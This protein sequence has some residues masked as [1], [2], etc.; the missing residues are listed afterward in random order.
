M[1]QLRAAGIVA[2]LFGAIASAAAQAQGLGPFEDPPI[3]ET[4]DLMPADSM[5][6]PNFSMEELTPS[7]G[8]NHLFT[9][10]TPFGLNTVE[11]RRFFE[12]RRHELLAIDHME[13][14]SRTGE[15]GD[16]MAKAAAGPFNTAADLITSPV[17]T[18]GNIISGTGKWIGGIWDSVTNWGDD[19]DGVLAAATGFAANKRATALAYQIDP[20]SRYE[21]LQAELKE[22]AWASF[23]GGFSVQVGF[24]LVPDTPGLILQI[25][26]FA[27]SMSKLVADNT[28][29]ELRT[30]NRGKLQALG[31]NEDVIDIFLASSVFS[32]TQQ[33]Y[34]VGA[35]EQMAGVENL[36]AFVK[37]AALDNTEADAFHRRLMA[38]MMAGYHQQIEPV[39]TVV[40]FNNVPFM[41]RADGVVVGTF[42]VDYV[43]WTQEAAVS[44]SNAAGEMGSAPVEIWISGFLSPLAKEK[45][46][47]Y[48]WTVNQD[49]D[50][51]L[52][53]P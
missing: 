13:Q 40:T 47:G 49:A 28:P 6:G 18:T 10:N 36:T 16:A 45:I 48:G 14:V 5:T 9:F 11:G 8:F 24:Q 32:P 38:E 7:N 2:V 34:L 23:A 22:I 42:P 26:S 12:L 20:Y 46:A 1:M 17:E 53:L 29:A 30:I 33:T 21:P 31:V 39:Q 27:N 35:L 19:D 44:V 25:G 51:F 43:S 50:K 37:E 3:F 15:F 4:K 41:Q 52:M